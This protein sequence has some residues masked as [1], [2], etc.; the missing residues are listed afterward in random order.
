MSIKT[1]RP[2]Q[3]QAVKQAVNTPHKGIFL[4]A[5]G[6]RGKTIAALAIA[7]LR[8]AKSILILNNRLS[9]L[10]GWNDA[11]ALINF[12][13]DV[14]ITKI[15]DRT[16]TKRIKEKKMSV[17]V[18]IID[19]WQN[20]SSKNL[21]RLYKKVN[22]TFTIGLSATPMRK[23]GQNMYD[24]EKTVFGYASPNNFQEW[25]HTFGVMKPSKFTYSGL[26]WTDFKDYESY[27]KGLPNFMT[28]SQIDRLE[29]A[30]ANN[31][32]KINFKTVQIPSA[33]PELIERFNEYNVVTIGN[34]SV[35]SKLH[36]GKIAMLRYLNSAECEID[37]PNLKPVDAPSPLLDFIKK[38][39]ASVPKGDGL[40]IVSRSR[41]LT[42]IIKSQNPE[43]GIWTGD[44]RENLDA[45]NWV[46]TSQTMGV[47]VDGLQH[48]FKHLIVLDPVAKD[49]GEHDDYKQLLWRLTGS[50]QQHD[51]NVLEIEFV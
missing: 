39:I 33:N 44:Q 14:K 21:I 3:L 9:I 24:L 22:R 19:E 47:G 27:T 28:M 11:I 18:L 46:A 34:K 13:K 12:D 6:G 48:K 17:D 50:R 37:F 29:N 26:E 8:G 23:A 1:L 7:K 41:Q 35:M 16:F 45:D 31:G 38:A 42:E 15:T 10:E 2:W 32:Y 49:S 40:L 43:L 51:V 36:F 30:A 25:Q 5:A 20:M 4:E